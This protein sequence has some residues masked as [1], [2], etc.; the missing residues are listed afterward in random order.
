MTSTKA[1]DK[2]YA[3]P[4]ASVYFQ[5]DR[6]IRGYLE[7]CTKDVPPILVEI[8]PHYWS[9]DRSNTKRGVWITSTETKA[10]YWLKQPHA[11][12]EKLHTPMRAKFGLVSNLIDVLLEERG[13]NRIYFKK[14][15]SSQPRELHD[16]LA[17]GHYEPF[18]WNLLESNAHF[19]VYQHLLGLT[20]EVHKDTP[21]MKGLLTLGN[22]KTKKKWTQALYLESALKAERRSQ[23]TPWGNLV[24]NAKLV[25]PNA[26]KEA[27]IEYAAAR[28]RESSDMARSVTRSDSSLDDNDDVD[29]SDDDVYCAPAALSPAKQD[30]IV[31]KN[32]PKKRLRADSNSVLAAKRKSPNKMREIHNTLYDSDDDDDYVASS[33]KKKHHTL[34]G[35]KKRV[36]NRHL[37]D[38]DDEED[39]DDVAPKSPQEPATYEYSPERMVEA[40][41]RKRRIWLLDYRSL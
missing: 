7:G 5:K 40:L 35:K 33:P 31:D 23:R 34:N 36:S 2:R 1:P 21:L 16:S 4:E 22:H 17:Y 24:E 27:V 38:S 14:H 6:V 13:G 19:F 20:A 10:W 29:S 25:R 8:A 39:N 3:L 12:Q 28:Q 15:L 18:D 11:S 30:V 32:K 9:M 41:V 26:N 37:A